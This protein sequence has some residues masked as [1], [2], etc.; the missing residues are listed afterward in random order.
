[1]RDVKEE[2]LLIAPASIAVELLGVKLWPRAVPVLT[3]WT[4]PLDP[5]PI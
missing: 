3:L 5:R 1:M 4:W 2:R